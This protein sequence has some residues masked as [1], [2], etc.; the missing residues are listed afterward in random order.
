MSHDPF[1][2]KPPAPRISHIRGRVVAEP[3]PKPEPG[4]EVIHIPSPRAIRVLVYK[5][6]E[7][8]DYV[9]KVSL[10]AYD[11]ETRQLG[12]FGS[13]CRYQDKPTREQIREHVV[14]ML[15]HEV[16]HHLGLDPHGNETPKG[17]EL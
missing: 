17:K 10:E 1:E 13:E 14:H 6:K 4:N 2:P 11:I 12:Y 3:A 9:S 16:R 15:D 7:K 5:S 8:G